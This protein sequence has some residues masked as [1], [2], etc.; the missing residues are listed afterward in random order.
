MEVAIRVTGGERGEKHL[1]L[2]L[3]QKSPLCWPTSLRISWKSDVLSESAGGTGY[4]RFIMYVPYTN[5]VTPGLA[6][7]GASLTAT[8]LP[9]GNSASAPIPLGTVAPDT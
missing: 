1:P 5:D 4:D 2:F 6:T 3:S 7:V 8:S 9:H